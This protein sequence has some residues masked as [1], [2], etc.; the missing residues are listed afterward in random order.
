MYKIDHLNLHGKIQDT[1]KD[2]ENIEI[3]I[4]H[5]KFK[6]KS[7]LFNSAKCFFLHKSH[8]VSYLKQE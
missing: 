2:A 8:V 6:A 7:C 1:Q 4:C 5:E 3:K